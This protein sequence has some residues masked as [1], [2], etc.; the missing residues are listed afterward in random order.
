MSGRAYR[1]PERSASSISTAWGYFQSFFCYFTAVN[2][3]ALEMNYSLPD[4]LLIEETHAAHDPFGLV[5]VSAFEKVAND[6]HLPIF[7]A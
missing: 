2:V 5:T 4:I 7:L 6:A 1:G 3:F